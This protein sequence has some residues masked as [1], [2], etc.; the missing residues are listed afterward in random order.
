[1]DTL[2]GLASGSIE[3]RTQ[4]AAEATFAPKLR[5]EDR[6]IDWSR[7][8]DEVARLVRAMAP[9]PGATTTFRSRGLKILRA[10]VIG[11][12]QLPSGPPDRNPGTMLSGKEHP[13]AVV[14]G[15]GRMVELHVV[16]PEGRRAMSGGEFVRGYRPEDLEALGGVGAT[17]PPG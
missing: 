6:V 11:A 12:V 5:A 13:L 1:V 2:D 4:E 10:E 3:E 14:T 9:D 7:P 16:Q 8:G 17:R 15:D